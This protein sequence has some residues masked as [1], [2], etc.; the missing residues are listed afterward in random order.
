MVLSSPISP[1]QDD[2]TPPVYFGVIA[3][4]SA[5]PIHLQAV[6]ASGQAFWIGK[7]TTTYCPLTNQ[8]NCPR[9]TDTVFAVGGG[10]A[11]LQT[12]VPGGQQIYVAPNG[13][14]KYTI[15]H[16]SSYPTGSALMT[17]NA[18]LGGSDGS[19]GHFTFEGLGATGFV[20]C[21]VT[22]D[23]P[24]QVFADVEGLSDKDVPGGRKDECLGFSALTAPYSGDPVWQYS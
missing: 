16:S 6:N 10:G 2:Y 13:A 9:G 19:L 1:R 7:D 23:G 18:T 8:A 24:Y 14:L 22:A 21:P 3:A 15:A 5:S 11:S 17:F 20:A 12:V 4:R